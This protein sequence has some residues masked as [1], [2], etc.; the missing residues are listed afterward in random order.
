MAAIASALLSVLNA[1]DEVIATRALYGGTYRLMCD[2][3]P[4]WA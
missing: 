2:I 3:F 4:P 1:G